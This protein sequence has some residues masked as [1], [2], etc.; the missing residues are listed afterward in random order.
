MQ[1][2]PEANELKRRFRS[3]ITGHAELRSKETGRLKKALDELLPGFQLARKKWAESQRKS[4]DDFNLFEVMRVEADEV[5]HSKILAWLLDHRIEKG[6]HA[7]GNLGFRLFLEE[8]GKDLRQERD[9]QVAAYARET[10]YRVSAEV[11]G[12]EARV[13]IEIAARGKFLIHIENKL[14][15]AEGENQTNREWRDC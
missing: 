4:A 8:I 9:G 1:T 2:K 14:F 15:S 3:L 5:C 7:Q 11:R 12:F 10:D 6:S 13:D